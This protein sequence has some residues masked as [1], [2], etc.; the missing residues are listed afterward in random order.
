MSSTQTQMERPKGNFWFTV[1]YYEKLGMDA[2]FW[3]LTDA[4][5]A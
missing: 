3:Y 1:M 2:T 4:D 5:N